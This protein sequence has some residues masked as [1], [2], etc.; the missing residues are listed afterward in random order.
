MPRA[1]EELLTVTPSEG[2]ALDAA[3]LRTAADEGVTEDRLLRS[4]S[5]LAM[6]PGP[7]RT[8]HT[9]TDPTIVPAT[10][11]GA[12]EIKVSGRLP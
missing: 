2:M 9:A 12:V 10:K 3:L 1:R 5:E 6:G 11:A 4:G 7:I 8:R